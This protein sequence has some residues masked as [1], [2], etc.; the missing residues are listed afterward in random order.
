MMLSALFLI[1]LMTGPGDAPNPIAESRRLQSEAMKAYRAKDHARFLERI[2]GASALR[3]SHPSLLYYK[4]AALALNG[5]TDEAIAV[6]ERVASMGTAMSPAK[7]PEF[8]PLAESPRFAAVLRVFESNRAP[9]GAGKVV[10]GV[11]IPGIIPEGLAHDP[12]RGIFY[13]SSVRHGDIWRITGKGAT[14]LVKGYP[15]ALMG[16]ALDPRRNVLW[17]AAAGLRQR[18]GVTAENMD[19]GALLEID[20]ASGKIIS[21]TVLSSEGRHFF[22]DVALSSRGDVVVSDGG[23]QNVYRLERG[24]LVPI[25][26]RTFT[27]VQGMAW[28]PDNRF[29]YVSDYSEGLVRIDVASGGVKAIVEPASVTLLGVDGIYMAGARTLVAVQNG[30][31]P[32]R[33]I[34]IDL[35]A[36]GDVADVRTLAANLPGLDSP[37]LGV[38]SGKS[39]YVIGNGQ[40]DLFADDG[41]VKDAA[42]LR[43]AEVL[44]IEIDR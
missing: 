38:V 37:T 18:E 44:E 39:F 36:A 23:S 13:L 29:L 35:T 42:K 27:S 24:K 14:R 5:R 1:A 16:L 10:A 7:E 4:A 20:A 8:A 17:A 21:E 22:G 30:T 32:N 9:Q 40:W 12:R 11:E 3:P 6:L 41:A 15:L 26:P 2:S 33:V 34:R 31:D 28:S 43:P 25:S 19:R